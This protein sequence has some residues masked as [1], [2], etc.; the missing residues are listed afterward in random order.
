M[1]LGKKLLTF[2]RTAARSSSTVKQFK[3]N[4]RADAVT[5]RHSFTFRRLAS[6][7]RGISAL[8]PNRT[9]IEMKIKLSV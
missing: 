8:S 7:G 1:S 3:K 6:S 4:N 5:E 2:Q 9:R